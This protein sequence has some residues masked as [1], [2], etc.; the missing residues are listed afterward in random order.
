LLFGINWII[1]LKILKCIF[2]GILSK[3]FHSLCSII[4]QLVN[5]VEN[6]NNIIRLTDKDFAKFKVE[7]EIP[8]NQNKM[9]K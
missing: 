3:I 6:N 7:N 2:K 8:I 5:K 1:F 9:E 4:L